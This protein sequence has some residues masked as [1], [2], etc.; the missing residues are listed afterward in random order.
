MKEDNGGGRGRE[1]ET[2]IGDTRITNYLRKPQGID[3][4]SC[5]I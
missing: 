3:L 4:C 5:L 1:E 2:M